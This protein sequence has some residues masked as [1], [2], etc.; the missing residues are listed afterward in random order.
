MPPI[1]VRLKPFSNSLHSLA[2][3][4]LA[5]GL[6]GL[7]PHISR[8]QSSVIAIDTSNRKVHVAA[9]ANAKRSVGGLTKIATTMVVLDWSE[10]SGVSLNV[11]ATV[12]DF[13]GRYG[14]NVVLGLQPGDKVTL[15]DLIYATM[16]SSD[17]AAPITLGHFVGN[18]IL[19]RRQRGGDSMEEFAKQMNALAAREGCTGTHF[20]TPHGLENARPM[21][22]STAADIARIALYATSRA[23][24]HFYANQKSRGITVFRGGERMGK[25]L[26]NANDL[27][28]I[29][30]ID[31]LKAASTERS[32]GCLA[33]TADKAATI[34]K[35]ADNS[36]VIFRHR[37][38]VIVLG[39]A[40]P[41]GEARSLLQQSWNA[42]DGWLNAGRP[43]TD[44]KQLLQYF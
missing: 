31:G 2:T 41:S 22:Y 44:Q 11:L 43:V 27:L 25:T 17:D 42:Y 19:I 8:A 37:M 34:I 33:I 32:G 24:F 12:P 4:A 26:S 18:D 10:A 5:L 36:S 13:V 40:N 15:R 6:I 7:V 1:A 30:R 39:S 20:V 9:N 29:D 23:P 35:Q 28:G 14:G 3:V 21:P 16:M 38:I